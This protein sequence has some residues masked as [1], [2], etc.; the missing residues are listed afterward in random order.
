MKNRFL[1]AILSFVMPGLGQIHNRQFIKA[2]ILL[3]I[4]HVLNRLA[5]INSALM[6]CLNGQHIES[7]NLL[8]YEYALF[9]P[10]FYALCVYDSVLNAEKKP[11]INGAFWFILTG[12]IGCLAIIYIRFVPIP[13]F[14]TGILMIILMSIG[15]YVCSRRGRTMN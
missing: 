14:T 1:A 9:Y 6:L 11:N 15:T 4:E 13:I 8:N 5:H 3:L 10:G 2:I 12:I 7:I